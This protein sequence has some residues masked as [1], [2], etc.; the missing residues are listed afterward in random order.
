MA[1]GAH[2]ITAGRARCGQQRRRPASVVVTVVADRR[3]PSTPHYLDLDGVDDYLQVADHDALSFGNGVVDTPLTFEIWFRP[4]RDDP[5]PAAR[6][7]G[8]KRRSE[9]K[10][11]HRRGPHP[12]STCATAA[13]AP[14][15]V[16]TGSQA[17]L[18]GAWHHLAVTYDGRG[19]ATAANGITIYVDGVAVPVTR[20]NNADYVAMENL[21]APLQIGPREPAW[22]QF[23]GALD[24]VRLWNVARTLESRFRRR[25]RSS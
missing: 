13:Q 2:T 18:V 16:F 8:D 25:G 24:D 14:V 1:D 19:G 3:S 4:D 23:D 9:Y 22:Q 12:R 21:A 15:S 7:V 6:Q 10:L 17:A 20:V 11:L 5:L